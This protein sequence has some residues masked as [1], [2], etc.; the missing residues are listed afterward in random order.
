LPTGYEFGQF[1]TNFRLTHEI[2]VPRPL[3]RHH[4]EAKE[5][6]RQQHLHFLV[7]RGEVA[8]WVVPCIFIVASPFEARWCQFVSS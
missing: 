1:L 6:I 3:S 8:T 7:M 4:E 5:S 2:E